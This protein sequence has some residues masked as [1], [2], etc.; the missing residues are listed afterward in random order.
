MGLI[1]VHVI[2]TVILFC[3][4]MAATVFAD[5]Q[6]T[7]EVL[8]GEWGE[9]DNEFGYYD[10][11]MMDTFPQIF[12][13]LSDGKV[14]ISD[15][16]NDRFMLF[17]K[18]GLFLKSFTAP[19]TGIIALTADRLFV[20]KWNRAKK[21]NNIGLF[22][23]ATEQWQWID[24]Q[25]NVGGLSW[26]NIMSE[27]KSRIILPTE[28]GTAIEYSSNGEVLNKLTDRPLL[29]GKE[30]R[31]G[32]KGSGKYNQVIDFEDT[33]YNCSVPDGF[34][35][36]RRDN[37]GYLYG[38]AHNVGEPSHTRVY[39][40]TK[41]GKIIGTVDFPPRKETFLENDVRIDED[42]GEPVFAQNGDVYTWKRTP[43][44][45][46]ILKW[47]WQDDPNINPG[48]DAP[49][50][51]QANP[52]ISG[53]YLTWNP[54]PQDPGCVAGYDI[55][56]ATSANG[57]YSKVTTVPLN[58]EQIYNY[59]DETASAGQTWYY[60]VKATSEIGDSDA[61]EASAARP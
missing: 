10:G 34:D 44:A 11:E 4:L 17:D 13:V 18:T 43:Q 56:R 36:F 12:D 29:F 58:A 15:D 22:N 45:Y 27:D 39:K 20:T 38:I 48:P 49:I 42:Y 5:W 40:I 14:I 31:S 32:K 53:I 30:K 3:L 55:E 51:V 9:A 19:G 24:D 61:A 50:E 47:T 21:M 26:M 7:I 16:A 28:N 6:E 37:A 1:R 59:N 57:I 25:N 41:C 33:T 2:F 60:K 46:S 23:V 35:Q 54:S 8:Q 52:S